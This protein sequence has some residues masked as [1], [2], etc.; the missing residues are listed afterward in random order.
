[1]RKR[2][3][4]RTDRERELPKQQGLV[5]RIIRQHTVKQKRNTFE[6][7]RLLSLQITTIRVYLY[8]STDPIFQQQSTVKISKLKSPKGMR[9][10]MS[11]PAL[12]FS[13]K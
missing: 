8:S 3:K 6:I 4:K 1:M 13:T 11:F 12:T 10:E 2:E 7:F 5:G 9:N